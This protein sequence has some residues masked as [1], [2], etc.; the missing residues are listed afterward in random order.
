MSAV[1]SEAERTSKEGLI[2]DVGADHG[3]VAVS[4]AEKGYR[5]IATDIS[6]VC[7]DKARRLAEST[8]VQLRFSVGDGLTAVSGCDVETVVICGMGGMEIVSILKNAEKLYCRYILSPQKDV[9]AVRETL[10][11][12]GLAVLADYTVE[13]ASKF[14]DVI[15]AENGPV[16][17]EPSET[18][19]EFGF[20]HTHTRAFIKR[21]EAEITSLT[22]AGDGAGGAGKAVIG[23]KIQ[24]L[25]EV[26]EY[27][28]SI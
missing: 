2:A 1:V 12:L 14:Y 26:L 5:V 25:R 17:H 4:L 8:G 23:K 27:A 22:R 10:F 20:V 21:T 13:S 7:L 11:R 9:R 15:V 3:K 24:K 18:E 16:V 19:L 6:A 28:Q